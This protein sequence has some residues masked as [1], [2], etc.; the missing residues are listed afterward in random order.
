M[1]KSMSKICKCCKCLYKVAD[2]YNV[3]ETLKLLAGQITHEEKT[4][5]K[6][7]FDEV[8]DKDGEVDAYQLREIL[9]A[10]FKRGEYV[11]VESWSM[12]SR[13]GRIGCVG[14]SSRSN[15]MKEEFILNSCHFTIDS[16]D[17]GAQCETAS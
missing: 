16:N 10:A 9:N 3:Q 6:D 13:E 17:F 15:D 11:G 14:K 8:A 2:E 1:G 7:A 12:N 4:D 5:F